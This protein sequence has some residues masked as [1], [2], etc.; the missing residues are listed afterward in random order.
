MIRPGVPNPWAEEAVCE[1]LRMRRSI[2]V[3]SGCVQWVSRC[4]QRGRHT[5]QPLAQMELGAH[6]E[7]SSLPPT[8]AAK[9][10][11]LNT[12]GLDCCNAL[13]RAAFKCLSKSFS[14]SKMEPLVYYV[15]SISQIMLN[16][17]DRFCI[18]FLLSSGCNS[19]LWC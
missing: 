6:T 8:R 5:C 13:Y 1:H 10:E 2:Y 11:S 15:I 9:P 7:P 17:S 14:Q 12:A 18:G 4:T 19:K 16:L 3:C